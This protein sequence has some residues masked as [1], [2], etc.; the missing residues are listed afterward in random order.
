MVSLLIY[1]AALDDTTVRSVI[2]FWRHTSVKT[3]LDAAKAVGYYDIALSL[4]QPM[5]TRLTSLLA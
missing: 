2:S 1:K 5:S 4:R 3:A